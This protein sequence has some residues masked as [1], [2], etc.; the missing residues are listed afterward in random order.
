MSCTWLILLDATSYLCFEDGVGLGHSHDA[1]WSKV[2]TSQ[3][4]VPEAFSR[5][6]LSSVYQPTQME[7]AY[8]AAELTDQSRQL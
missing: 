4:E 6:S 7:D 5:Q 3:N 8:V 1:V 2:E